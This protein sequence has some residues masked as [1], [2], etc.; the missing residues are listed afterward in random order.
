MKAIILAAGRGSRM[1]SMTDNHPKCLVELKGKT[2]LEWQ[3]EAIR[4][5]GISDIAIVTGYKRELLTNSGLVKFHNPRWEETNMVTSLSYAN[6]WLMDGPCIV[7]YSDIFYNHT[8]IKLLMDCGADVAITYD[9][10]WLQLWSK[11]FEDPLQDAETFR[12]TSDG[13]LKEIGYK[14][15]SLDEV[16]GQYMGLVRFSPDAWSEIQRIRF[17]MRGD[18]ADRLHMTSTIQKVID[19]GCMTIHAIPYIGEWGEIDSPNDLFFSSAHNEK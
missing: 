17:E 2:L 9:P 19:S 6:E 18:D 14:P 16:E 1:K 15:K 11:R 13:F 4:E 7:S 5:A 8:A 10:N 3:L 12:L